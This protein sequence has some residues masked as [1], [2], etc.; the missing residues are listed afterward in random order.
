MGPRALN[1]FRGLEVWR[2]R[3]L[4]VLGVISLEVLKFRGFGCSFLFLRGQT[5]LSNSLHKMLIS[6]RARAQSWIWGLVL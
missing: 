5:V 1:R 4:E 3:G 6:R 2:V